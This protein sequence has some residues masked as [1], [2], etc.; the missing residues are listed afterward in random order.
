MGGGRAQHSG[1]VFFPGEVCGGEGGQ[2]QVRVELTE[3]PQ[4]SPK[5]EMFLFYQVGQWA[6]EALGSCFNMQVPEP[7]CPPPPPYPG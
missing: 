3:G 6:S 4:G 2:Q 1:K 7:C 5:G